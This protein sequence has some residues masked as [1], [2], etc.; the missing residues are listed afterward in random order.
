MRR[1]ESEPGREPDIYVINADGTNERK[2]RAGRWPDW[3]P[4]GRQIVF[5]RGGLPGG[6]AKVEARIFICDAKGAGSKE[7]ALGDCPSWSPDGKSIACCYREANGS[8][9]IHI[10][11]LKT[12]RSKTAGIGW[13]RANWTPDGKFV[14]ANGFT[15]RYVMVKLSVENPGQPPTQV[16]SQFE[17]A[18]SPCPSSDGQYFIFLAKRPKKSN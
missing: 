9:E 10:V 6:G 4:D 3:S 11:D 2:L 1:S 5:S 16:F 12:K 8:P 14:V 13:F 15:E 7:I 18:L 17:E